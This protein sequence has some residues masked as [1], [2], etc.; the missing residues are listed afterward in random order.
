MTG[1]RTLTI[2]ISVTTFAGWLVG[3]AQPR[4]F[5]DLWVEHRP[6]RAEMSAVRPPAEAIN[7]DALGSDAETIDNPTGPITLAHAVELSLRQDPQLR[8]AGW[9]V[10]AAEADA[11]QQGRPRNP[12]ASLSVEN[13]GGPD[14]LRELPRQTLRLSQ[15]IELAG[16]RAKRQRLGEAKQRLQ[17]WNYEAKRI[18]VAAETASRYVAVVVAQ[19]RLSLAERQLALAT[20]AF[21]IA[22]DRADNGTTPGFERDQAATRVALIRIQRDRAEQTLRAARV[23]LAA[24]WGSETDAFAVAEGRIDARPNLPPK[25]ALAK[26]LGD[27]PAVARWRDEIV[28]RERA[29]QL[30]RANGVTDPAIGGGVRYLSEIDQ[31]VGLAEVSWPLPLLDTNEHGVLAA[32]LRLSQTLAL[33][34]AAVTEANRKL[35]VVYANARS[36]KETLDTL[37][38]QA[39][40][41]AER[42]FAATQ[43]AYESGLTDY[44]TALDAERTLLDLQLLQLDASQSYHDAVIRLE[45]L[46][47]QPIDK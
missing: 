25:A 1:L 32:R 46:T 33:R 37:E 28:M 45:A 47:A 9:S 6:Y 36:A 12:T 8:A 4:P 30:Q 5:D 14:R 27:S 40:P 13:F 7:G 17:A 10:A 3:C 39:I 18:D 35:S 11:L 29:V 31:T 2:A 23:D 26:Q 43:R 19:E 15:V 34:D 24:A 22:G 42:A 44:L 21:E 38:A 20:S 41:A 16:K